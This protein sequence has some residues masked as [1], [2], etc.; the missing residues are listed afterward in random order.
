M[1]K[2]Q[3]GA[4][5]IVLAIVG[6][7]VAGVIAVAMMAIGANNTANSFDAQVKAQHQNNKNILANYGQKVLEVSQ[8]PEM[9][10]DDLVKV[11]SAAIEGRYGKDGSKAVFQMITEQN[12]TVDSQV[13]TKIQQVI[14]AGRNEFQTSQT[15]LLDIKQSYETAL[16]SFPQGAFMRFLGYP[17]V[18]LD[19]YNIVTTERTER[20]FEK[21]KEDGPLQLRQKQL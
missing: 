16:G 3:G 15:R 11:A 2:Q 19:T 4:L 5:L 6:V 17:K 9:M 20:A 12:P 18:A 10:R 7:L 21:G 14:E 1:K 13:Y 8:V